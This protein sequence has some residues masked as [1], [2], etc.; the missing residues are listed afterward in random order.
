[1]IL[2]M[3]TFMLAVW[4]FLLLIDTVKLY[5]SLILEYIQLYRDYS[6]LKS[7]RYTF[8]ELQL[9]RMTELRERFD[10]EERKRQN[11]QNKKSYWF[12]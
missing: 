1:M 8:Y 10:K 9:K 5:Y 6:A 11:R 2:P 12:F 4:F 3:I 7:G